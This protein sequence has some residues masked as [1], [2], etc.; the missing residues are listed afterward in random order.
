MTARLTTIALLAALMA[1]ASFAGP[2]ADLETALTQQQYEDMM[3]CIGR[4]EGEMDMTRRVAPSTTNPENFMKII[5]ANKPITDFQAS[6]RESKP[7]AT[8][9]E[10]AKGLIQKDKQTERTPA[11]CARGGD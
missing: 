5:E 9:R 7:R 3:Y 2:T 6:N 1:S 4:N 8:E 11:W 10:R